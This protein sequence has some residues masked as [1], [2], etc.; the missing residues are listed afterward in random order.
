MGTGVLPA[1]AWPLCNPQRQ[2]TPLHSR[3]AAQQRASPC[4][5]TPST[6]CR[7]GTPP[8]SPLCSW[9]TFG[10]YPQVLAAKL[11]QQRVLRQLSIRIFKAH[12]PEHGTIALQSMQLE[13]P[14]PAQCASQAAVSL[15]RKHHAVQLQLPSCRARCLCPV[16]V[17]T[18][19]QLASLDGL[20][21][22][23]ALHAVCLFCAPVCLLQRLRAGLCLST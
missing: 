6:A 3:Q 18:V 13:R 17:A 12:R 22:L 20:P 16:H 15:R 7:T 5:A 4:W 19:P 8:M 21:P 10:R 2:R 14:W 23:L 9:T 11:R 1:S